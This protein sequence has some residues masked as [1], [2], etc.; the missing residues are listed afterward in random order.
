MKVDF[1]V[2][3]ASGMQGR[4][5]SRDLLESGFKICCADQYR[6]GS[7]KNLGNFP[8]TRFQHIDLR[9]YEQLR[10]LIDSVKSGVVVNC[11][12]GDWDLDVYRACLE[13]GR[14][15]IDLGS[16]IP[17]TKSQLAMNKKF[18][19]KNITAITGCGSTPGI[20]NIM[21]QYASEKFKTIDT[22]ELGFA[23]E[24]NVKKFV[25]PF[26]FESITE[27]LTNPAPVVENGVW[28]EKNPMDTEVVKEFR[29]IGSQKCYLV[30]H[31]ETYTFFSAYKKYDIKNIRFYA[32]FPNHSLDILNR[33]IELGMGQKNLLTF[34]E[35]E[36][37][38]VDAVSRILSRLPRPDGYTER[39]NLWVE[40]SGHD[41]AG[42]I[43]ITKMEC[44]VTT[45][46]GWQDAGCNI[47]TGL[48]ASIIAQM[49]FDGRISTKGSFAPESVVPVTEFFNEIKK[50]GMIVYQNGV[51]VNSTELSPLA[52]NQVP[53]T[54]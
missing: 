36:I 1:L 32:G 30:R 14:N 41:S 8:G 53:T 49:I 47:D 16:E 39:E 24:S 27:E 44:L 3:G 50:W 35:T 10:R 18:R 26:S 7:E 28:V 48:P 13:V 4:I 25:V 22:V 19:E 11:A 2:L 5:V 20:N 17:M 51:A 37:R 46:P 29:E 33:L 12:E 45:L 15:V 23:W 6:D 31:P 21:F 9:D 52:A 43:K 38:P 40:V 42:N 54:S 34:E